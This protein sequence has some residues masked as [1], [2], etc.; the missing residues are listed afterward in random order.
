M[1]S[2]NLKI[3]SDGTQEGTIIQDQDGRIME[4]VTDF[5]FHLD[6]D[7]I[8]IVKLSL[9]GVPVEINYD[10]KI[11]SLEDLDNAEYEQTTVVFVP[12]GPKEES[13]S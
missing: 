12:T 8:P 6:T 11:T 4:N 9:V 5:S 10:A 3:T 7:G 2:I 13:A 1:S